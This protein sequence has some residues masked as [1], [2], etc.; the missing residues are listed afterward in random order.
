MAYKNSQKFEPLWGNSLRCSNDSW[1]YIMVLDLTDNTQQL[2]HLAKHWLV[3][4]AIKRW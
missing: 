4:P 3:S 1:L 2:N